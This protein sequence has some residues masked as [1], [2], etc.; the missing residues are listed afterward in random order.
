MGIRI[1]PAMLSWLA[2]AWLLAPPAHAA[3]APA[4]EPPPETAQLLPAAPE[5]VLDVPADE[6]SDSF[7]PAEAPPP[8]FTAAQYI[9]SQGCV[10]VR[11][12]EGWRARIARDGSAI[13]GYPPT[14]SARR[15]GPEDV[16]ALFAEPEEPRAQRIE[17][18]LTETI[19][20]NL[21]EGELAPLQA[22][23]A[24][25]HEPAPASPPVTHAPAPAAA[26]PAAAPA[27][28]GQTASP[29]AT[30]ALE[31][32]PKAADPLGFAAAVS[33]AS[34]IAAAQPERQD[35]LCD[36]IGAKATPSAGVGGSSALGL[37]GGAATALPTITTRAMGEPRSAPAHE[38]EDDAASGRARAFAAASD[39][40]DHPDAAEAKTARSRLAGT[41]GSRKAETAA[42]SRTKAT[43]GKSAKPAKGKTAR[44]GAE[45][46]KATA[47]GPMM[48]PPGARFVQIG[49][50]RDA[51]NAARTATRLS[52]MGLP[53]V[54][55]QQR[56]TQL[57]MVGPLSG[58][59]AIVRT[60]DRVRQAG[61]RD[62][63]ARR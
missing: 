51:G 47:G 10:F 34:A 39:A 20:P 22:G 56:D 35:R 53:V 11:V 7:S 55:S 36:L 21:Q 26:A 5:R 57:I 46:A 23:E 61:Y 9:D 16:A 52:G 49:A 24:E 17:R 45:T 12:A 6:I 18:V 30:A 31:S 42:A 38:A 8:D 44:R 54:R 32:P 62:A 1:I 25:R 43:A 59:E 48:I 29:T 40:A 28:A 33:H 3:G 13:C 58:R 60:I 50:F 14:F 37:C 2:A 4:E 27:A 41:G 19:L 15:T 63:Y